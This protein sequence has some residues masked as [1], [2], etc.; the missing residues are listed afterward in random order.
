MLQHEEILQACSKGER[1]QI[2][3]L[4]QYHSPARRRWFLRLDF[5]LIYAMISRQNISRLQLEII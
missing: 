3:C 2:G 4:P 1:M 5:E